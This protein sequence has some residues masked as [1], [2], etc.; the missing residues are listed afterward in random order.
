MS[1]VADGSDASLIWFLV[2]LGTFTQ[3]AKLVLLFC[4]TTSSRIKVGL[5]SGESNASKLFSDFDTIIQN[6]LEYSAAIRFPLPSFGAIH[7]ERSPFH[8]TEAIHAPKASLL[9]FVRAIAAIFLLLLAT[10]FCPSK[11]QAFLIR[12]PLLCLF[13]CSGRA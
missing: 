6:I 1:G 11:R 7:S 3:Q 5:I 12:H 8:Q 9:P 13:A 4:R 2:K 10:L